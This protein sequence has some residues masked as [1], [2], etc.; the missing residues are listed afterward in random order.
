M[1]LLLASAQPARAADIPLADFARHDRYRDVKISQDGE[2]LAASAIVHDKAVLALIHLADMKG[3]NIVPRDADELAGFSWVAPRRVMYSVGQKVGGLEVPTPTGELYTVSAD[4]REE[5]L[6]FGYRA[7]GQVASAHIAQAAREFA[8]G[9]LI[10]P[11]RDNPSYALI[12]S[13]PLTGSNLASRHAPSSTGAFPEAYRIELRTGVKF[14]VAT[15]PL[16]NA[17]FL[18]DPHGSVRMAY[19]PDVDQQQKVYY[20]SGDNADWELVF[21]QSRDGVAVTPDAFSHDGKWVY[22]NCDGASHVGGIC[23]WDI[24]ARK[25]ATVWSGTDSAP[26]ELLLTADQNGVVAVGSMPGRPVM[27]LLDKSA[28]EARLLASMMEKFPGQHVHLGTQTRDGRKRIVSVDSDANPGDFYLLDLDSKQL[29]AG[30]ADRTGRHAAAR[31]S[32][33]ATGQ[34]PSAGTAAGRRRSRRPLWRARLLGLFRRRANAGQPRLRGA[35]G[36]L[37]R[38]GRLWHR[39]RTGGFSP[40]G[41]RDAGRCHRCDALGDRAGYC[42]P[43]ADCDLRRQLW[44]LCRAAGCDPR[45]G[46][47]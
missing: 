10:A 35:A 27:A 16:R 9:E 8:F 39:V 43:G 30:C 15:S 23:R 11:L 46:S 4:G 18:A 47:V 31:L 24:A 44:R 45:T 20:R 41:R 19:G 36:Q 42:R 37:P 13:Y 34:R 17:R 3:V 25:L 40:M 28:P 14:R 32:D 33:P 5:K 22:V 6:I 26:T 7:G 29:R 1:V 21:D 38:L 2:Y 12:A